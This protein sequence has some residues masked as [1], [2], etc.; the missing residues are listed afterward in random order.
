[1]F[2]VFFTEVGD[3]I[4][5]GTPIAI[6]QITVFDRSYPKC[7][8]AFLSS[9]QFGTQLQIQDARSETARAFIKFETKRPESK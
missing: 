9:F 3:L 2:V 5:N 6:K 8:I 7:L 1:M 4:P